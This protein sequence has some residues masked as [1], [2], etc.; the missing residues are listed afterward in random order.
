[1]VSFEERGRGERSALRTIFYRSRFDVDRW[2]NDCELRLGEILVRRA[3][4]RLQTLLRFREGLILRRGDCQSRC[5]EERR[6]EKTNGSE[7]E[8][9]RNAVSAC[10]VFVEVVN[11]NSAFAIFRVDLLER[12]FLR[13]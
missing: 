3:R 11:L 13:E 12:D 5:G 9:E 8:A 10:G 2:L 4:P 6:G 1:M 7:V